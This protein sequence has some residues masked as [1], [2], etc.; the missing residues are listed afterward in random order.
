MRGRKPKPDA[1]KALAGNPGKRPL[2]QLAP[3]PE[4][5]ADLSPPAWLPDSAM[6]V[7]DELAPH[8]ARVR[9]LTV[10]DVEALAHGCVAIAQ[11]R[12]AVKAMDGDKRVLYRPNENAPVQLH[13]AM[14]VQS[15]ASKQIARVFSEF[16]L[17]PSARTRIS[18]APQTDLFDTA[19][20]ATAQAT[21][22]LQ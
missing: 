11:Y 15:M 6:I 1:L 21:S 19:G 12:A 8:L 5:L 4:D 3:N 2:N 20:R 14:I 18:V 13:P 16:G 17:T 9:L 22:Y 7:W 10:L